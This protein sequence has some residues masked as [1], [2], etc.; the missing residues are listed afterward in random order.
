MRFSII[1]PAYNRAHLIGQTLNSLVNQSFDANLY[2]ILVCDNNSTDNTKSVVSSLLNNDRNVKISYYEEKRQ[3]VHYARNSTALKAKGSYLYFTDDDM[4]ADSKILEEF[5]KWIFKF[6]DLAVLGGKVS[7]EWECPPP[8][9][10]VQYF[11]DSTLSLTKNNLDVVICKTDPGIASCHQ[12]I[13]KDVFL[14]AGGFRPEYTKDEWLGDGECGLNREISK[15][16]YT[17][18]SFS[19]ALT[20]HVIPQERMTMK[21]I[22]KRYKNQGQAD[23]FTYFTDIKP[24]KLKLQLE[25][26]KHL[27][28]SYLLKLKALFLV[29]SLRKSWRLALAKSAQSKGYSLYLLKLFRSEKLRRFSSQSSFL[30]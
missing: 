28:I 2:E 16:G 30:E 29:F 18:G 23:A 17:F 3:G 7:P 24:T 6:P 27:L 1:I 14:E 26:L 22:C 5:D 4:I 15:L 9:W 12:L 10:L 8:Y 25:H 13:R 11:C 21:Y 20:Q 19:S